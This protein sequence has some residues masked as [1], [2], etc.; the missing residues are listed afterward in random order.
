MKF[1]RNDLLIAGVVGA[2]DAADDD[3]AEVEAQL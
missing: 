2:L 3:A 1:S